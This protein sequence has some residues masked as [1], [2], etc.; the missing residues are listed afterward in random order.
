MIQILLRHVLGDQHSEEL[1]KSAMISRSSGGLAE[2]WAEH[3]TSFEDGVDVVVDDDMRDDDDK[4]IADQW[5]KLKDQH[6]AMQARQKNALEQVAPLR[7]L[8]PAP[9]QVR[10]L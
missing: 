10:V 9:M 4:D 1:L 6:A 5:H 3:T 2:E 8:E 7:P